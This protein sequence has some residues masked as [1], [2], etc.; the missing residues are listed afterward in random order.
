MAPS[1]ILA[2]LSLSLL[3]SC[4]AD[5][6]SKVCNETTNPPLCLQTLGS[7]PRAREAD[8]RGLAQIIIEKSVGA[9]QDVATNAK[10][11][12]GKKADTCVE[13]S[14]VAIDDLKQCTD[15]LKDLSR[16]ASSE[17]STAGSDALRNVATCDHEFGDGE[18]A[19]LKA[20]SQKAQ[21]LINVLLFI[22]NNL[23]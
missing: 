20:A 15:Y 3:C 8:L 19:K 11:I 9:V 7:D 18:P 17:I 2:V 23:I 13:V 22:A 21:D 5:L 12:G 14:G 6:V 10:S 16:A 1:F 4:Q